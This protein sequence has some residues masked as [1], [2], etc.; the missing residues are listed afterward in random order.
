MFKN[1]QCLEALEWVSGQAP[2]LSLGPSQRRQKHLRDRLWVRWTG[3]QARLSRGGGICPPGPLN[4]LLRP[5]RRPP[6][7]PCSP[8]RPAAPA[9]LAGI[10]V[11]SELLDLMTLRYSDSMGR[12]TFPSLV[13]FLMRLE[14]MASKCLVGTFWRLCSGQKQER[15][16]KSWLP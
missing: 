8:A 9:F 7:P 15:T 11:S 13:C 5:C 3:C 2:E 1:S 16:R 4:R 6:T 12:V 14:A 10:F